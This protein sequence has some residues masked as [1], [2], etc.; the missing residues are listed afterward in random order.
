MRLLLIV[1]VALVGLIQYP[2]WMGRGGWFS[3]WDMQ[4]QVVDQRMINEG[5]T[6]RNVAL[7]AEVEDLRSGTEASEERARSELGMMRQGEVFVQILPPGVK[8]PE[9]K[10]NAKPGT[11]AKPGI[12]V[13]PVTP[14]AKPANPQPPATKPVTR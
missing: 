9:L 14:P 10:S 7:A 8:P 2:L 13:K 11:A 4:A 5:L 12:A 1:M 6:A 3:V